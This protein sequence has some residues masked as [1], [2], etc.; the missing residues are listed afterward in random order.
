M[1]FVC[2]TAILTAMLLACPVFAEPPAAP[3]GSPD[4]AA[5]KGPTVEVR[6]GAK[7]KGTSAF[8]PDSIEKKK[9]AGAKP[10]PPPSM[11]E[12]TKAVDVLKASSTPEAARLSADKSAEIA[13]VAAE[14]ETATKGYMAKNQAE[15]DTLR[16]QLSPND[17]NML[18]QQLARGGQLHLSKAG[19]GGK[20]GVLKGKGKQTDVGEKTT[21]DAMTAPA[22]GE[23]AAKIRSRL[24]EIYAGR[25]KVT[26]VQ[27]K[28][29]GMLSPEQLPL[30]DA[31]LAKLDARNA[32]AHAGK[33]A[34]A[35]R[36]Q[37]PAAPKPD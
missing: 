16:G 20:N 14:F 19:F 7:G 1:R 31:E 17:R 13:K 22:K 37:A 35:L 10:M 26:D 36:K 3:A 25:P 34:R 12:F 15:L 11:A 4:D 30:V 9:A 8:G 5:L 23:E 21:E 32:P 18:D 28:I 27:A 6:P 2:S 29:L 33:G 24:V